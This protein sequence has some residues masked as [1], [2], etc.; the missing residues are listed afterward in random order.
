MTATTET[1]PGA[2]RNALLILLF[3]TLIC[4]LPFAGKPFNI[5]EPLFIWAAHQIQAHPLNFYGFQVNWYGYASSAA[6][7]IKNPPLASYY[8]A[9]VGACA[10]WSELALHLA[11]VVP[12]LAA[13]LGSYFLAR[14]LSPSPLLAALIGLLTPVFI[15]CSATV[16]CDTMMLAGYL[17]AVVLWIRGTRENSSATMVLAA[18]LVAA[19]S[20][21][22]YF[23]MSLVP[24]LLVYSLAS[25]EREAKRKALFLLI[26]VVILCGYQVATAALYGKGLLLDAASY[27]TSKKGHSALDYLDNLLAGLSFVGGCLLPTLFFLPRLW[28]K[29]LQGYF[30]ILFPVT[31]LVLICLE[32][33][34]RPPQVSW[35]YFLQLALFITAGVHVCALAVR[36]LW[37]KR[38]AESLLIFL[39]FAGT[40]I[41]AAFLNWSLNGRSVLPL[42][43]VAGI[44][45]A[46]GWRAPGPPA[47][48]GRLFRSAWVALP[49]LAAWVFSLVVMYG[50]YRLAGTAREAAGVIARSYGQNALAVRFQGHWGFQY[51][52]Q[53]YGAEPVDSDKPL[54]LFRML[55]AQPQNNTNISPELMKT[56]QRLAVLEFAPAGFV[57]TMNHDLGAGFYASRWG[58]LPF[59]F[60][61]VG[62]EKYDLAVW[63]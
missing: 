22:K 35:S 60:G 58:A 37:F 49:L 26:P 28:E 56:G 7:V 40:F 31:V 55:M 29:K 42:V 2:S 24:L 6:E 19:C 10:G 9:L 13:V 45:V 61:T 44:L 39:W 48:T 59:V 57:T 38:D 43:S 46:R 12:A 32:V 18:F 17:W 30:A 5:D 1:R 53:Q 62:K 4:L 63:P 20:L 41:F 21:T 3:A 50:D 15:L 34:A 51:Y 25:K 14:E 23:G 16:M 27:A 54:P 33:P 47:E 11:F 36:D 8:L 52:M